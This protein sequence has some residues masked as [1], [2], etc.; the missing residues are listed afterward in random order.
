MLCAG[1]A[2]AGPPAAAP[3]ET[4]LSARLGQTAA[5]RTV[6]ITPRVVHEDSR[7]P[8]DAT[9]IQAGILRVEAL[10]EAGVVAAPRILTVGEPIWF[11]GRRIELVAGC[12]YPLASQPAPP[13]ARRYVFAVGTAEPRRPENPPDY[14]A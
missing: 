8:A 14:C 5:D 7:C 11:G 10:L 6:R 4:L 13:A 1:C 3:G 12:P 9:C 2:T